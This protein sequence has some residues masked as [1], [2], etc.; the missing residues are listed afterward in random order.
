MNEREHYLLE[1]NEW[2]LRCHMMEIP[3]WLPADLRSKAEQ[4]ARDLAW[5]KAKEDLED[6]DWE[7]S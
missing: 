5:E 3:T 4:I 2:H 6:Y 7:Y 1:R